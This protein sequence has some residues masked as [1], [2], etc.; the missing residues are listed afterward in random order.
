M[1]GISDFISTVLIIAITI[2]VGILLFN[3]IEP[4]SRQ[5]ADKV[6]DDSTNK[7]KCQSAS[8]RITNGILNY[9]SKN[10]SV[11]AENTGTI[12]LDTFTFNIVMTNGTNLNSDASPVVTLS[13][14][15]RQTMTTSSAT[16]ATNTTNITSIRL[17]GLC[18]SALTVYDDLDGS[19][20]TTTT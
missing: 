13:P 20:L 7:L 2:T 17:I 4:L 18:N 15:N 10:I 11:T 6:A 3:W 9:T 14:S 1:K 5:Q 19:S 12:N 8:L 16:S